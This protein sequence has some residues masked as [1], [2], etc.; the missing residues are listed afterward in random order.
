MVLCCCWV[1]VLGLLGLWL[2]CIFWY[3]GVDWVCECWWFGD[4]FWWL[5]V[6]LFWCFCRRWL[7]WI[8]CVC[9]SCELFFCLVFGGCGGYIVDVL[10][11]L[12]VWMCLDLCWVCFFVL[13][14]CIFFLS[15]CLCCFFRL[16]FWV[17]CGF[18]VIL[19]CIV[20]WGCCVG[21]VLCCGFRNWDGLVVDCC[22]FYGVGSRNCLCGVGIS[23]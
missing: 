14:C 9:G 4:V 10:D 7:V 3:V 2:V 18:C 11:W 23:S 15:F 17:V 13:M 21:F 19:C 8:Y 12:W 22:Y 16:L 20:L 5:G 1:C 6:C